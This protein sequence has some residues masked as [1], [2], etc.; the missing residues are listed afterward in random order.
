MRDRD[1]DGKLEMRIDPQ[2]SRADRSGYGFV[3]VDMVM[4][5]VSRFMRIVEERFSSS[6]NFSIL[7]GV[8]LGRASLEALQDSRLG[9]GVDSRESV[10]SKV[11]H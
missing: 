4:I 10:I 6:E 11:R 8:F 7:V 1:L 9:V 3:E 2:R 5:H